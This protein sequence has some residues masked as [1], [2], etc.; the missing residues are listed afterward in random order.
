MAKPNTLTFGK[1]KIYVEDPANPGSFIAPCGFTD[2][3]LTLT[4]ATAEEEIPDCDNPD[5][6][7]W[8]GRNIKSLSATVA[9]QGARVVLAATSRCALMADRCGAAEATVHPIRRWVSR[10]AVTATTTSG[11]CSGSGTRPNSG[12]ASQSRCSGSWPKHRRPQQHRM[13][14][15]QRR[16][17]RH[18][19]ARAIRQRLWTVRCRAV[20]A[21][22]LEVMVDW[23]GL[24]RGKK[25]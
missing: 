1:F 14:R 20:R 15:S 3:S 18:G 7:A 19:M 5:A 11:T 13:R 2:K 16:L 12:V 25:F 6:P 24:G 21:G 22:C 4:A 9:G 10:S 23:A 17:W 8:V